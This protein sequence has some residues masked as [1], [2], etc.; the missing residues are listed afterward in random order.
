LRFPGRGCEITSVYAGFENRVGAARRRRA[1]GVQGRVTHLYFDPATEGEPI[2][3]RKFFFWIFS[4]PI[5]LNYGIF[6]VR[7]DDGAVGIN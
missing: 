6:T 1:H 2:S 5:R 4:Y 7:S 3:Q